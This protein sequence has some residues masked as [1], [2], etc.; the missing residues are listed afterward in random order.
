MTDVSADKRGV[1]RQLVLPD[2]G[3][4]VQDWRQ[5]RGWNAEEM[6]DAARLPRAYVEAVEC[7][8][9]DPG[10]HTLMV[11]AGTL[12]V[13]LGVLVEGDLSLSLVAGQHRGRRRV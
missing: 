7:G 12:G 3:L 4:S 9:R 1:R 11:L 8:E 5:R 6:A 10:L 13:P 2:F